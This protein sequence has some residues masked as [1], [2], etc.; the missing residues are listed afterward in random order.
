MKKTALSI[1]VAI[2]AIA[3][4]HAQEVPIPKIGV[5]APEFT[6]QSTNGEINFPSDFGNHWKILFSHPKDFTPVCTS[7]IIELSHEQENFEKMG[8]K[9]AV[10]SVDP[11]KQHLS[12]KAAMEMMDY[13]DRYTEKIQFPLVADNDQT[14][15]RLYGMIHTT[16]DVSRNV[17][18][19][20]FIDPENIIRAI[21]F[22]PNEV[23]R[24]MDEMKRTLLALQ[25]NYENNNLLA[26]ADWM[27]GEDMI[28]EVLSQ[29]DKK[30][31]ND[32]GSKYYQYSW[33]LV[34]MRNSGIIR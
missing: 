26:P 19:V 28:V 24:S 29:E 22:Y 25:A 31:I 23:G 9:I 12:W 10:V 27:P 21:F 20:Y 32:E 14:I 5:K 2:L 17:R 30:T 1:I 33:F 13:K 16:E 18:G 3:L 34:F 4:I 8:T 7:E 11:L 6:A 15:A